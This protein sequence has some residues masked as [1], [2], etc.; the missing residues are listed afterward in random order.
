MER[1]SK[2]N[3]RIRLDKTRLVVS[4][5]SPSLRKIYKMGD[6]DVHDRMQLE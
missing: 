1:P 6:R 5:C 4:D 3:C 2:G